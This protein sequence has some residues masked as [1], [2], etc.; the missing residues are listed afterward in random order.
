MMIRTMEIS[1]SENPS[2][3]RNSLFMT[4]SSPRTFL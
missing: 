4:P 2:S 3:F 1:T